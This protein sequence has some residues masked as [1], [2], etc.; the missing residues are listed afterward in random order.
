MGASPAVLA[1]GATAPTRSTFITVLAWLSIIGA[2]GAT[3]ISLMQAAMYFLVFRDKVVATQGHWP[4]TEQMPGLAQVFFSHPEI[5]IATFCSLSVL[6][7]IAA[8]GLLW[9]KN[10]ARWYFI[11]VL[12]LGIV[13]DLSNLWLQHQVVSVASNTMRNAGGESQRS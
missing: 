3:F 10:W 13:W 6:T 5:L 8:I 4:G 9:R 7:F 2:G 12:A 11:V 1:R